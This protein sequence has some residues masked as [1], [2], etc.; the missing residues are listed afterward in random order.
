MKGYKCDNCDK[1]FDGQPAKY[2][3]ELFAGNG[4]YKVTVDMTVRL[5]E[6]GGE[7]D[8]CENCMKICLREFMKKL[9]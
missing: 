8:L 9:T 5:T 4:I 6:G 2:F 3:Y 1:W 7:S